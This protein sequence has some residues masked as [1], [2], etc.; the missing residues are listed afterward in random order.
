M[1]CSVSLSWEMMGTKLQVPVA[2]SFEENKILV[3]EVFVLRIV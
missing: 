3:V 1:H 2:L